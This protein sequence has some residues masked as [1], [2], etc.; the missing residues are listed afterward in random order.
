MSRIHGWSPAG[1]AQRGRHQARPRTTLP[2]WNKI[3]ERRLGAGVA[4]LGGELQ[5]ASGLADADLQPALAGQ[6]H[7]ADLELRVRIAIADRSSTHVVFLRRLRR[8]RPACWGCRLQIGAERNQRI[9]NVAFLR[10]A[11]FDALWTISVKNLKA[12]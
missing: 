12:S 6:E 5:P 1:R 2:L 3:A 4:L 9:G 11:G 7:L 10:A 8:D